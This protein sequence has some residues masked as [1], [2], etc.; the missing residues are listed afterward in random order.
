MIRVP[1]LIF[2]SIVEARAFYRLV[3]Q[4]EALCNI[5]QFVVATSSTAR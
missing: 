5:A 4:E 2:G 3:H 1:A